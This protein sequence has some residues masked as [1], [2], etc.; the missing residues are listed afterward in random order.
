MYIPKKKG[1]QM[2]NKLDYEKECNI[3][4]FIEETCNNYEKSYSLKN[5]KKKK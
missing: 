4:C 3:D 5:K 2:A 1:L